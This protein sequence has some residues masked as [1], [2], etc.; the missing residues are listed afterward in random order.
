MNC[1]SLNP[2]GAVIYQT[3]INDHCCFHTVPSMPLVIHNNE[4]R[5]ALARKKFYIT[6][7]SKNKK[8]IS[9]GIFHETIEGIYLRLIY[10]SAALETSNPPKNA[11]TNIINE[12]CLYLRIF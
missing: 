4:N 9:N 1:F 6:N 11:A 12:I 10:K 5:H 3:R 7:I 2:D 8:H